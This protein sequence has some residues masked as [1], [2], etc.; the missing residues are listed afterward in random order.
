MK[1][2][3]LLLVACGG[4]VAQAPAEAPAPTEAPADAPTDKAA[5]VP[6]EVDIAG[7]H[8][9]KEAGEVPVLVDVR[10]QGEWDSGHVPGAVHIPMDQVQKRMS[11]LEQYKSGPVY[12]ICASGGRS[13]RVTGEL[14]KA[15][16][17]A[18]TVQGGTK[19]WQAAG[20]PVE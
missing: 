16:Y 11:E 10:T 20:P 13:G 2:L 1:A 3:V 8:T 14:R 12:V 17:Q 18:V 7:F 6:S 4:G 19:G 5:E 15:G 9:K